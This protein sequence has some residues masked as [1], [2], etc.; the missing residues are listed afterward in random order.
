MVAVAAPVDRV[1]ESRHRLRRA[2]SDTGWA[3]A[4]ALSSLALWAYSLTTFTVDPGRMDG[5]GLLSQAPPTWFAAALLSGVAL[6]VYAIRGRSAGWVLAL[7]HLSGNAVLFGTTAVLSGWPRYAWSYKHIGVADYLLSGQPLDR[8]VDIYQNWPGFFLA[9]AG[10]SRVTGLPPMTLAHWAEPFFA[11]LFGACVYYAVGALSRERRVR[12]GAVAIY[13]LAN[14]IGQGYFAPQAAAICLQLVFFGAALRGVIDRQ[15]RGWLTALLGRVGWTP[16]AQ[17]PQAESPWWNGALALLAYALMVTTH[18]LTPVATLFQLAFLVACFRVRAWWVVLAAPVLEV[19]W[20]YAAW[21]Y[22]ADHFDLLHFDATNVRPPAAEGLPSLPW[23]NVTKWAGP[24]ACLTG[25]GLAAVGVLAGWR[26]R[27]F[28]TEPIVLAGSVGLVVFA[29]SYG[30]EAI[31]RVYV[32][33]LPWLAVLGAR[34]LIGSVDDGGLPAQRAPGG[35]RAWGAGLVSVLL[36]VP[37]LVASFAME[38]VN[39]FS[40]VDVRA[41]VWFEQHTPPGS[42]ALHIS[43]NT[44]GR[45]TAAYAEHIVRP[46]SGEPALSA[47]MLPGGDADTGYAAVIATLWEFSPQQGYV[48]FTPSQR[49]WSDMWGQFAPGEYDRAM[50]LFLASAQ[51]DLVYRDGDAAIL[52]YRGLDGEHR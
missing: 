22:L 5:R 46:G 47:H 30:A 44:P 7:L 40:D 20:V 48:V 38:R 13:L 18:Q 10:V 42:Y 33:A 6:L 39:T 1:D 49:H 8:S 19:A 15:P 21:G 11:A 9:A 17:A 32:Y 4:C 51:F 3:L 31:M 50:S 29:N 45:L 34:F 35:A 14:W 23:M 36:M 37:T 25:T 52:R 12:W 28:D 43:G 2:R 24:V 41:A 26:R 16:A 27:M